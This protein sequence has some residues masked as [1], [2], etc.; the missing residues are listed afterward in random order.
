MNSVGARHRYLCVFY[1][2]C[3]YIIYKCWVWF[4][5]HTHIVTI[6]IM[7]KYTP[8][9]AEKVISESFLRGLIRYFDGL[10]PV[11]L[12][13]H[14]SLQGT[15]REQVEASPFPTYSS[16]SFHI[17]SSVGLR[18]PV[19]E[20]RLPRCNNEFEN[21]LQPLNPSPNAAVPQP[22][23]PPYRRQIWLDLSETT[24]GW[25]LVHI[26]LKVGSNSLGPDGCAD[27]LSMLMRGNGDLWWKKAD[28]TPVLAVVKASVITMSFSSKIWVICGLTT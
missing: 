20:E 16:S 23:F 4:M 9:R 17:T 2:M 1:R 6:F 8:S 18:N 12:Q 21:S 25:G 3:L 14:F 24:Q 26:P 5:E 19:K 11:L 10:F 22:F 27:V 7:H 28:S 13:K 15:G